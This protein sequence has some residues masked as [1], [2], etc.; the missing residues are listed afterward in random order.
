MLSPSCSHFVACQGLVAYAARSKPAG[1]APHIS[2][3]AISACASAF[4]P[5]AFCRVNSVSMPYTVSNCQLSPTWSLCVWLLSTITG[6]V[7]SFVV[8]AFRSPIPHPGIEEDSP[9]SS[10]D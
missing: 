7:V 4:E 1:S 9:F 10:K 5:F 8:T 3:G 6:N 2:P